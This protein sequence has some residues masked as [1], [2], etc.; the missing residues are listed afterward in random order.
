[1][2]DE[3]LGIIDENEYEEEQLARKRPRTIGLKN[4]LAQEREKET[5][6]EEQLTPSEMFSIEINYDRESWLERANIH[7]EVQ[8]EKEKGNIDL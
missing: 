6:L 7:L 4:A 3:T 8:L 1:M 5:E 2:L